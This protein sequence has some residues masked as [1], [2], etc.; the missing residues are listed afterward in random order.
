M[1]A[2]IRAV[3][4]PG[5]DWMIICKLA[6]GVGHHS[7]IGIVESPPR[8]DAV[9]EHTDLHARSRTFAECISKLV[10][11]RV[12]LHNISREIYRLFRG[13]NCLEHGREKL[14]AVLEQLD[15][16]PGL[17][18]WIAQRQSRAEKLRR[19]NGKGVIELVLETFPPNEKEAKND[20]DAENGER[21]RNPL[22]ERQLP[23]PLV[24]PM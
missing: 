3:H 15:L 11:H 8:A 4:S 18:D 13:A 21:E 24:E 14:I 23:H 16:V 20:D 12:R 10:T 2:A 6:T 17:R 9:E 22:R 19:T 5:L 1:R 7:N